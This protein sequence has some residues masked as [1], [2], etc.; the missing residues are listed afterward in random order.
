[1]KGWKKIY[2][3]SGPPKQAGVA[4]FISDKVDF[5]P[6]LMKRDKEG[7][8]IST[9]EEID[10][11][12]ITIINLYASNVNASNFIKHIRKD[13]KA[14]INSNTVVV[15]DFNNALPSINR[16]SKQKINKEILDLKYTIHQIE[17]CDVYRTC[18]PTSTQYTFFSATHGTFSKT[19]QASANIRK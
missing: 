13:I 19:K 3:G 5:K 16:S 4:I 18:H 11:M 7:H 6:T 2:Q 1:M 8:F 9:K 12:A 14:Y 10:Q 17:L 15:G